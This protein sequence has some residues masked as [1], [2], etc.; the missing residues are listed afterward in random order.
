VCHFDKTDGCFFSGP[1]F[2]GFPCL[3]ALIQPNSRAI[4]MCLCCS[5]ADVSAIRIPTHTTAQEGINV[6]VIAFGGIDASTVHMQSPD[7]K[8]VVPSPASPN[9]ALIRCFFGAR[10]K[11]WQSTTNLWY[12]QVAA[13]TSHLAIYSGVKDGATFSCD[14][15]G[16]QGQP[17]QLSVCH[18]QL[19]LNR[20]FLLGGTQLSVELLEDLGDAWTR[21]HRTGQKK[22]DGNLFC[23]VL[24]FSDRSVLDDKTKLNH[25]LATA[26]NKLKLDGRSGDVVFVDDDMSTKPVTFSCRNRKHKCCAEN[27]YF[28]RYTKVGHCPKFVA[29]TMG[30][31]LS[32]RV[33]YCAWATECKK[34]IL[35]RW[36]GKQFDQVFGDFGFICGVFAF[37]EKG[38]RVCMLEKEKGGE[39]WADSKKGH[40][41]LTALE[42]TKSIELP[43][44]L[45]TYNAA[46]KASSGQNR[47]SQE[48]N[49]YTLAT[50]AYKLIDTTVGTQEQL[51]EGLTNFGNDYSFV[52][53]VEQVMQAA[54]AWRLNE[55]AGSSSNSSSSS[56]SNNDSSSSSSKQQQ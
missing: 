50:Q 12:D 29:Q 7:R 36:S 22:W 8:L 37:S 20:G 24:P 26:E 15:E 9:L 52:S 43:W 42:G 25:Q 23:S 5:S 38:M 34:I 40:S 53:N 35:V 33:A 49:T 31:C 55:Q 30:P 46:K 18:H 27:E 17:P 44:Y 14:Q 32:C 56:S 13:C 11:D 10:T 28:K 54:V 45:E 4:V 39:M 2:L 16:W 1:V 48:R 51:M 3:L 21:F 41:K 6:K 19:V 47:S